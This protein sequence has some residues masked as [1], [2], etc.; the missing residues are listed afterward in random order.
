LANEFVP[1]VDPE[2]RLEQLGDYIA[3][4]AE[5]FLPWAIGYVVRWFNATRPAE[6]A[7]LP[8]GLAGF[9]RYGVDSAPALQLLRRGVR[10][11]V[12]A[13]RVA[14]EYLAAEADVTLSTWLTSVPVNSWPRRFGTTRTELAE[15]LEI[16]RVPGGAILATVLAGASASVPVTPRIPIEAGA[17]GSLAVRRYR[18][19]QSPV[20]LVGNRVAGHFGT[21][22]FAD[23]LALAR[24][25]LPLAAQFE[26]D[27]SPRIAITLA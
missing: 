1:V 26:N 14:S 2:F 12:L 9:V 22:R 8:L 7:E 19:V 23:V 18:Q 6:V 25:G 3:A 21:D 15:L 17:H 16:A 24:S 13:V 10:S 20:F 11:R 5:N 27:E 4:V